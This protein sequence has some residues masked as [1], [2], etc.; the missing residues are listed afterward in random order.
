M[1]YK[2]Y[3]GGFIMA[4]F[5]KKSM[6]TSSDLPPL[7]EPDLPEFPKYTPTLRFDEEGFQP[8]KLQEAVTA[9]PK[10][11]EFRALPPLYPMP[12]PPRII[13][14]RYTETYS[15]PSEVRV[16]DEPLFVKV[17]KY[18]DVVETLVKIKAKIAEAD[19]LLNELRSLRDKEQKELEDWQARLEEIKEKLLYIDKNLFEVK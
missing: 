15:A 7:Q 16:K 19:N 3:I 1:C 8:K 10:F 12:Q 11:P 9:P 17:E 13:E 5:K 14:P 18:K 2:L 6:R 4:L